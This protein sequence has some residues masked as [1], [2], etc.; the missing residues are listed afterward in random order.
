MTV[1][2][3]FDGHEDTVV[4]TEE[5]VDEY[6]SDYTIEI[7]PYG[8]PEEA[9]KFDDAYYCSAYLINPDPESGIMY[10]AASF[11]FESEDF[12]SLIFF[13]VPDSGE[14][15][16]IETELSLCQYPD[17]SIMKDGLVTF[18]NR[19]EIMG[20]TYLTA[21]YLLTPEGPSP[22]GDHY[23]YYSE[24]I[25]AGGPAG[26]YAFPEDDDGVEVIKGI[27]VSLIDD[28]GE[29]TETYKLKRGDRVWPVYT[30]CAH[31]VV[32]KLADGRLVQINFFIPDDE[33]TPY[34]NGN[35]QETYFDVIYCD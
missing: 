29:R 22:V 35:P 7:I 5:S 24:F 23:Y 3:D 28:R 18:Q 10:L 14:I 11:M 12:S 6:T 16:E 31:F 30:D 9:F 2:F 26:T 8:R 19:T 1:D 21:E 34:M 25:G 4:I 13:A 32:C 15:S 20:T 33:F 17:G 27:S